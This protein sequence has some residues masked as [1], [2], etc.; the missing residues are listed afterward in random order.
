[1]TVKFWN[2]KDNKKYISAYFEKY[3]NIWHHGDYAKVNDDGS[4]IIFGRS[5]TTLNPG[6]VRLGTSAIYTVVEKF[7]EVQES[8]VVGQS[9]QNDIR[10]ILFVVLNKGYILSDDIISKIK[11]EIRSNASPRHV[12]SK[13]IQILEVPKTKNGKLVELAVKQSI[14]GIEIKNLEALANPDSLRQ[15]KNI[16]ELNE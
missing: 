11:K 1:M 8:I 5:D 9:W 15:F 3:K 12:P 14:E 13:I 4:F 10:I 6:G 7:K 2:D 16:K